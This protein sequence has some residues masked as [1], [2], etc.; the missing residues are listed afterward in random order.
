MRFCE[1]WKFTSTQSWCIDT[2]K[3]TVQFVKMCKSSQTAQ[4]KH[5]HFKV[6]SKH[7]KFKTKHSP[8][9]KMLNEK[10]FK[11]ISI[12]IFVSC[13]VLKFLNQLAFGMDFW[14]FERKSLGLFWNEFPKATLLNVW[15][16][17]KKSIGWSNFE[18]W[19]MAGL[20][21]F[22]RWCSRLQWSSAFYGEIMLP[23]NWQSSWFET[24]SYHQN[25]S[26]HQ[27][28]LPCVKIQI[29]Y[30]FEPKK[31]EYI[32]SD[33]GILDLNFGDCGRERAQR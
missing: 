26:C 4:L 27:T 7:L 15:F 28:S 32:S 25:P 21:Q 30:W 1:V 11:C 20:F 31:L 18:I 2:M 29:S 3:P 8:C 6:V 16:Q 13:S 22:C 5:Q 23:M 24:P 12:C 14:K 19:N 33:S 17:L 9:E 10:S